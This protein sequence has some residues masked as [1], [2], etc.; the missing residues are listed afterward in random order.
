M[1]HDPSC[2]FCKIIA[3]EIP[4]SV[5]YEDESL[6]AFLDVAP[7]ADGHLLLVPQAHY[8]RLI[9]VPA[10]I[11]AQLASAFPILGRALLQVTGAE[12]FNLLLNEGRVAGQVV[13]HVH[14]HLIPRKTGDQLGY[15]WNA[16]KYPPGRDAELAA[17][18]QK[19]LT[20]HPD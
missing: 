3:V 14:F 18:F 2:I 13:P 1:T 15:R 5:V 11:C 8:A 7:L 17:A 9:D 16:G 12:G 20:Q 10:P 19:A 6:L 4:A